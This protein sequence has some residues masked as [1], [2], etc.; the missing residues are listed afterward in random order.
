M[1]A[2]LLAQRIGKSLPRAKED[3]WT[4]KKVNE[5]TDLTKQTAVSES[6][7]ANG[8]VSARCLLGMS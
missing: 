2:Q 4:Q 3:G 1:N 5:Q 7:G 8:T 6:P